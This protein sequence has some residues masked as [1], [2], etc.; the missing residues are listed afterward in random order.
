MHDGQP[1]RSGLVALELCLQAWGA[2]FDARRPNQDDLLLLLDALAMAL[3]GAQ[4]P[5]WEVSDDP[6]PRAADLELQKR[7]TERWRK[8]TWAEYTVAAAAFGDALTQALPDTYVYRG[9]QLRRGTRR[10]MTPRE[11]TAFEQR[12]R[13]AGCD[14]G[15][16]LGSD[17]AGFREGDWLRAVNYLLVPRE[18]L[19]ALPIATQPI[20]RRAA[21]PLVAALREFGFEGDDVFVTDN[22]N[23]FCMWAGM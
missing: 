16:R 4:L 5:P 13:N 19:K 7:Q 9:Q 14:A 17:L 23:P 20:A 6:R 10:T 1:P 12:L 21:E 22:H 8:Q 18:S 11:Q 2:A 15:R 3:L